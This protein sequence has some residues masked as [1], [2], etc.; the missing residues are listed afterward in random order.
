MFS[1]CVRS[2]G[3]AI[4]LIAQEHNL[5]VFACFVFFQ[6]ICFCFF[7]VMFLVLDFFVLFFVAV[8]LFLEDCF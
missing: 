7:A 5:Y 8:L 1:V 4:A 2:V 3:S 6:D